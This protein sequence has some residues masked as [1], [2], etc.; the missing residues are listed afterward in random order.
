MKYTG[1]AKY[2]ISL[3]SIVVVGIM[4]R[5]DSFLERNDSDAKVGGNVLPPEIQK[6]ELLDN[7]LK[8]LLG[9]KNHQMLVDALQVLLRDV[10]L[11]IV[12]CLEHSL[13]DRIVRIEEQSIQIALKVVNDLEGLIADWDN[14]APSEGFISGESG[15]L[16]L[17]IVYPGSEQGRGDDQHSE[18]A[19]AHI[20][21][22]LTE[23]HT[24]A[25]TTKNMAKIY[26]LCKDNHQDPQRVFARIYQHSG[27]FF[28]V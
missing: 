13:I 21:K 10:G 20:V 26:Q 23:R 12:P 17:L 25:I 19:P 15:R 27:G 3:S 9:N 28:Q 22:F 7:A 2:I 18:K 16:R 11:V 1:N 8:I 4:D 5:M 6:S 14:L 24:A